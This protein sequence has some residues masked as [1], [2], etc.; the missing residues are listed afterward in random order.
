MSRKAVILPA[1]APV[2]KEPSFIS[3][4]ISQALMWETVNIQEAYENWY[5]IKM[6]DIK[7]QY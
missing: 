7:K 3:E 1:V 6:E 2:H 5:Q 4:M